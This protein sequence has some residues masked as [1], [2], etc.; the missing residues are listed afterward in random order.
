MVGASLF[1]DRESH[2]L[3]RRACAAI[4]KCGVAAGLQAC[5]IDALRKAEFP[6]VFLRTGLEAY[7]TWILA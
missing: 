3:S 5:R 2:A 6:V 1:L 4:K 7:A